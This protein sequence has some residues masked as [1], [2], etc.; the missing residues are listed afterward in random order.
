MV[1]GHVES[2]DNYIP[3][4]LVH[5]GKTSHVYKTNMDTEFVITHDNTQRGKTKK[6]YM[7]VKDMD[8]HMLNKDNFMEIV[9]G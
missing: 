7:I 4:K 1:N 6:E 8:F 3:W 5:V 2:T 9:N